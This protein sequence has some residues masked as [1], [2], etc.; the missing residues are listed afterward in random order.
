MGDIANGAC[1]ACCCFV[2][3][4]VLILIPLSLKRLE[5]NELG[6]QYTKY[7]KHL[8]DTPMSGGLFVYVFMQSKPVC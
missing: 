1:G 6:L 5:E 2:I 7:G 4:L 3:L 8:D